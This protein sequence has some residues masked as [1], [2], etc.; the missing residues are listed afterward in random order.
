[1]LAAVFGQQA[2]VEQPALLLKSVGLVERK[3]VHRVA[4]GGD[5][6]LPRVAEHTQG[7]GHAGS[8]HGQGFPGPHHGLRNAGLLRCWKRHSQILHL[9]QRQKQTMQIDKI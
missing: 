2:R 8:Q 9:H 3:G 6:L 1:M 7:L 4:Q 5:A